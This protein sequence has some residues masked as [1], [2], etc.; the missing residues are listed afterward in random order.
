[1]RE[2]RQASRKLVASI[3]ASIPFGNSNVKGYLRAT[4]DVMSGEAVGA[5]ALKS[6]SGVRAETLSG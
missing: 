6:L 4:R 5:F 3:T 1:M 2:Y